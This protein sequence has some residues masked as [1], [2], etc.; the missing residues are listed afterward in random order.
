MTAPM[1]PPAMTPMEKAQKMIHIPFQGA[2]AALKA[3]TQSSR[4]EIEGSPGGEWS[5]E[6][7]S[8]SIDLRVPDTAAFAVDATSR[9]GD[10]ASDHPVVGGVSEKHRLDGTVRGGGPTLRIRTASSTIKVHR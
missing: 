5:V 1:I 6:S 8:G 7:G 9:S 2:T 3:R 10:I 4:I